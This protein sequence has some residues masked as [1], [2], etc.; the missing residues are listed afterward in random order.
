VTDEMTLERVIP[1][2]FD[3]TLLT[4]NSPL[5]HTRQHIIT[6]SV[7]ML[8]H[9]P[10]A[11]YLAGHRVGKLI[12][13]SFNDAISSSEHIRKGVEGSGLGLSAGNIPH[14]PGAAEDSN[15]S[16]INSFC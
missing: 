8:G 1:S 15:G 5:R 12:Y 6:T 11:R 9:S 3:F 16:V 10:L 7:F 14:S 13:A 2:Y 4:L